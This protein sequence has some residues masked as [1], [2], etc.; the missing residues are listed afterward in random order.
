[1]MAWSKAG[2]LWGF[3]SFCNQQLDL[4]HSII[5]TLG[6]LACTFLIRETD[7]LL[8]QLLW[9][10]LRVWWY[11]LGADGSGAVA[12]NAARY[13]HTCLVTK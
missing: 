6:S 10:W 8:L 4:L 11:F 2:W 13:Q 3:V 9:K 7:L 12:T 1:M 5:H